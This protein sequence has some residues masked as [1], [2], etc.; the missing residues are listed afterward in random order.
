MYCRDIG[1][2]NNM[3]SYSYRH[4]RNSTS[5]TS[6]SGQKSRS[7]STSTPP[8]TPTPTIRVTSPVPDALD[9]VD[10]WDPAIDSEGE[11]STTT[12]TNS[13]NKTFNFHYKEEAVLPTSEVVDAG[14]EP[15]QQQVVAVTSSTIGSKLRS[16]TLSEDD[17]LRTAG[18]SEESEDESQ[19]SAITQV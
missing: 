13:G 2:L 19:T 6:S 7:T 17:G 14:V 18:E 15:Q 1:E 9:A 10:M 3:S 11:E 12:S 8:Q 16:R 5:S 4:A